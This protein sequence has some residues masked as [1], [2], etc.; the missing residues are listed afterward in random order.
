MVGWLSE[1]RQ[2]AMNQDKAAETDTPE[3]GDAQRRPYEAPTVAD[4]FQPIVALGTTDTDLCATPR[5]PKK[6]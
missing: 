2:V 5:R 4:F 1:Q 3:R 6:R